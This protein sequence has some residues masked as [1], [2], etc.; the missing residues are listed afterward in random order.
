[1]EETDKNLLALACSQCVQ[2]GA[3][4][5]VCPVHGLTRREEHAPRG[6]LKL[7]HALLKGEISPSAEAL[8]PLRQCLLC[9]RCQKNCPSKIKVTEAFKEGRV[10]LADKNP[11]PAR[12]LGRLLLSRHLPRLMAPA[13][14]I[15]K[16][17]SKGFNLCLKPLKRLPALRLT[18]PSMKEVGKEGPRIGLFLGCMATYAR[19]GL[20]E[21]AIALLAKAGTVV[22]L[23]GCCGLA[24]QSSGQ[25]RLLNKAAFDLARLYKKKNLSYVVTMCTSCAHALSEEHVKVLPA[26]YQDSIPQVIDII[27][28]M[29]EHSELIAGSAA[30]RRATLHYSCH[31]KAG[32]AAALTSWLKQAEVDLTIIDACCGGGGLLPLNHPW[33]SQRITPV[34][35]NANAPLLT[36]CS[37]CYLQW[38][39]SKASK[40][41]HPLELLDGV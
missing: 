7:Y 38:L 41:L 25:S 29:A 37:G 23:S 12:L 17:L 14:P 32:Q 21:K 5:P 24:A 34:P 6:R 36:T 15:K 11:K 10:W 9:G 28:F 22:P 19:P 39:Q 3:C 4:R 2:C 35:E 33:L 13:W 30:G 26:A 20:A 16:A 31:L 27:Q 18:P 8:A 1:M 40:V